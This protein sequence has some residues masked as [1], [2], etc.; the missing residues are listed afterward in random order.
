MFRIVY[1]AVPVAEKSKVLVIKTLG[2]LIHQFYKFTVLLE[3]GQ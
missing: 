2:K 1:K 3:K